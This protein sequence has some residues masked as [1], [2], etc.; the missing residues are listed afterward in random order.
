M[1]CGGDTDDR[2]SFQRC[3]T[4]AALRLIS[5]AFFRSNINFGGSSGLFNERIIYINARANCHVAQ[6]D[7]G[8]RCGA[9]PP[10]RKAE[11]DRVVDV[12]NIFGEF[13]DSSDR[14][15]TCL[16]AS[17]RFALVWIAVLT[18][19]FRSFHLRLG[20]GLFQGL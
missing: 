2:E 4:I 19:L 6:P 12:L 18:Y 9:C 17:T 7:P 10:W 1:A 8:C 20:W 3:A 14:K 15:G 13:C 5:R 16:D 11:A